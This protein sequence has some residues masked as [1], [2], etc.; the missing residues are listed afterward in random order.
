M[1]FF[2]YYYWKICIKTKEKETFETTAIST[3]S[4]DT[5]RITI[6][7]R[8]GR[9]CDQANKKIASSKLFLL[10][11]LL[12][13]CTKKWSH[14]YYFLFL[15]FSTF[16]LLSIIYVTIEVCI[17]L[18]LVEPCFVLCVCL[19]LRQLPFIGGG[20]GRWGFE[21]VTSEQLSA[22]QKSI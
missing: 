21:G 12:H 2:N 7:E 16:S 6:F 15:A 1:F 13:T 9:Q 20:S 11:L 14:K 22:S 8:H 5:L 19:F 10:H 4:T 3:G 17:C 18:I